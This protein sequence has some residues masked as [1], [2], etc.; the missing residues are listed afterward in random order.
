MT[1]RADLFAR[2]KALDA[3]AV[4]LDTALSEPLYTLR[5]MAWCEYLRSD[6]AANWEEIILAQFG[7]QF[8]RMPLLP[9]TCPRRGPERVSGVISYVS[10]DYGYISV[11]G[12]DD[13]GFF[14]RHLFGR[15]PMKGDKVTF[16]RGIAG[17]AIDVVLSDAVTSREAYSA[18]MA[19][20]PALPRVR[21]GRAN[22]NEGFQFTHNE[23]SER[24][25]RE[26]VRKL[27]E[28]L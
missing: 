5:T 18:K 1:T 8:A 6:P 27:R 19:V 12:E 23:E 4:D 13:Y 16:T 2:Y 24:E 22:F 28:G 20:R 10:R 21:R 3:L 26:A 11:E 25:A 17:N 7:P 15:I 9:A 14:L